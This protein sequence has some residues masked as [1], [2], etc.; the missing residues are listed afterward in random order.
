MLTALALSLALG[1]VKAQPCRP[2]VACTAELVPAGHA[3]VEL[4]ALTGGSG[5]GVNLLAKV[6]VLDWL[7]V[8]FGS[9]QLLAFDGKQAWAVDG[10]VAALK[11]RLFEQADLL[12][13][14][15][16]SSRLAAPTRPPL[17]A[18]QSTVDLNFTA[19]A[20]KDLGPVHAD[21]NGMFN[22]FGFDQAQGQVALALSTGLTSQ[23]GVALE[24]HSTFGNPRRPNDGGVRAVLTFSP[25]EQ[26]VFDLGGDVGFFPQT[27]AWSMFFGLVFVPTDTR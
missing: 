19:H 4:G 20:S 6:S 7:Q 11:V 26:L 23:V 9:D 17:P 1:G 25:V 27:R 10:A 15:S 13:T 2:T 3:E 22:L 5:T 8:Q 24:G 18:L 14:L 16:L 12:P 21:L